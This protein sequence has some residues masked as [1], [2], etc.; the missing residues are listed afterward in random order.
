MSILDATLPVFATVVIGFQLRRRGLLP[1]AADQ[2][3]LDFTY[4]FAYPALILHK[5]LGDRQLQDPKNLIIPAFTALLFMT[6]G[7]G[8]AW[9]LAPLL[10]L[11]KRE[12]KAAFALPSAIQNY[13]FLPLPILESQ[14]RDQPWGGVL[15]VYTLGVELVMWILGVMV[16]SGKFHSPWKRL[17]NP[18]VL[19]ILLGMGISFTGADQLLPNAV[20]APLK[21]TLDMLGRVSF[22]LGILM[23]GVTLADTMKIPDWFR[24]WK[25]PLGAC[26]LRLGLFPIGM[27]LFAKW[28]S[29]GTAYNQVMAVQAAM[30][31]AVFPLV[32]ARM[33][34]GDEAVAARAILAT[35]IVSV[36][37]VPFVLPWALK[38]LGL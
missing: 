7:I 38:F 22:P 13:G 32:L 8:V 19:S 17:A 29:P 14:F 6:A 1:P 11:R 20:L 30:P 33:H 24:D 12:S 3:I 34:G 31:S 18:I 2:A 10:G 36:V 25:V 4:K 21:G 9:L 15:F 23:F 37:T 16:M 27:L 28:I 5:M 35:T 26:L